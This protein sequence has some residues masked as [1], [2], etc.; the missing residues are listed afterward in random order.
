MIGRKSTDLAPLAALSAELQGELRERLKK[1]RAA[2]TWEQYAS[3]WG[4]FEAWCAEKHPGLDPVLAPPEM[5]ALYLHELAKTRCAYS[6]VAGHRAAMSARFDSMFREPNPTWHPLVKQVVKAIRRDLGT[7][8]RAAKAAATA[9]VMLLLLAQIVGDSLKAKRDRALLLVGFVG[10]FRRAALVAR[11]IRDVTTGTGGGYLV[12]VRRDKSDQEGKGLQKFIPRGDGGPL[13]AAAALEAWETAYAKEGALRLTDPL[14]PRLRAGAND[15]HYVEE[16]DGS[17]IA[18]RPAAVA[19]LIKTLAEKAKIDPKVVLSGHSLRA[20]FVTEASLRGATDAEIQRQT[21]HSNSE[22]I[23][24]YR[25]FA[26]P[27]EGNAAARLFGIKQ[28]TK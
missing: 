24:R 23:A 13:D 17:V 8:P 2:S 26:L 15:S 20:G 3:S 5:C 28:E 16:V 1:S 14:F 12:L 7:A 4:Q 19:D 11:E 9:D 18:L 22:M 25:R 6:T 10:A 21:G 27:A